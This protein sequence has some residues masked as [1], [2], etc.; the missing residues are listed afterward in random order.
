MATERFGDQLR[1]HRQA[2]GM[3]QEALA[4][5]SGLS[6][7]GISDLE[8]GVKQRPHP[9]TVRLLAAALDLS[10][11]ALAPF[12]DSAAPRTQLAPAAM[13]EPLTGLVDRE[14]EVRAVSALLRPDAGIRLV[15][16]TGPG[17]VG[18]TRLAIK[19]AGDVHDRF[20]DGVAFVPLAGLTD[21]RLVLGAMA[22]A[23]GIRE[24]PGRAPL[25]LLARQLQDRQVLLVLDNVEHLLLA[26]TDVAAVLAACRGLTVLAT[27]R[28]PLHISG[29]QEYP[30]RP[31]ALPEPARTLASG[32]MMRSPAVTLFVRQARAVQPAFD[33]TEA[34]AAAVAAICAK[35][36][37]LPLAL[38]LAAVRM[39][40]LAPGELDSLLGNRL[41]ILTGGP[42][43]HPTRHRTMRST[44]GWSHDLMP[45]GEQVA[46]RN[47]AVFVGG[48]TLDSAATVVNGDT[49]ATLDHLTALMDQSLVQRYEAPGGQPRFVMLETIREYALEQLAASG[50]D[51]PVRDR[52]A[53]HFLEL[54]EQGET[55][56]TGPHQAA[57]MARLE[58]EY[59]NLRAALGWSIGRGDAASSQR[60]GSALWRFWAASGRLNEGRDWLDRALTLNP[61]E[62]SAV[63]AQALLRRGN[64]AVD[65]ADY[66][67]ARQLYAESLSI[68]TEL[69]DD[70]NAC[71]AHTGMGLVHW[72]QGNYVVA[73]T[74]HEKALLIGEVLGWQRGVAA[75]WQNVGSVELAEGNYM[76]AQI[77]FDAS[78]SIQRDLGDIG[79]AA[80]VACWR[81]RLDRLDGKTQS[82]KNWLTRALA[83]FRKVVNELGVA[84]AVNELG[85]LAHDEGDHDAAVAHHLQAMRDRHEAGAIQ[86]TVESLEGIA[87]ALLSRLQMELGIKLLAATST[88]RETHGVPLLPV[89]QDSYERCL[90]QARSYVPSPD[91]EQAWGEGETATIDEAI[92]LAFTSVI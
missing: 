85:C 87:A 57:W 62:Q 7:R 24:L 8:R 26:A 77:A 37:G 61:G 59:G 17:G 73:R 16:L 34:N 89:L 56:L 47:F 2:A 42:L 88:W 82:A 28:A 22:T 15:T 51:G 40:T 84:L 11:E 49:L 76:S 45:P 14:D 21:P 4:E 79:G 43:D 32:E 46:F 41:G 39:K 6:V 19:V 50:D 44:I 30:V 80:Y 23:L 72:N 36:D 90:I 55:E 53:A 71:R 25:D 75:A 65:L 5:R 31:L 86:E 13:P 83:G 52:H 18:K 69:N 68:S 58:S 70:L 1:R 48:A 91:F 20:A 63:R 60:F 74:S 92:D 64:I 54:A 78:L 67:N 27:S 35:V 12:R 10:P 81:G 29:E 38:E 3:T 9:E 33:V 66:P